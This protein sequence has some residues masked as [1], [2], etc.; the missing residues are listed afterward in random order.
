MIEAE[1]IQKADTV[2]AVFHLCQYPVVFVSP[3]EVTFV[4]MEG[5]GG[6]SM[7]CV[8]FRSALTSFFTKKKK[9]KNLKQN[10][11]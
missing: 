10:D 7:S 4:K 11:C 3:G 6:V 8:L 2:K 5:G 9:V 1:V